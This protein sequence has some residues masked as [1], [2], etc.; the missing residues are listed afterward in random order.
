MLKYPLLRVVKEMDHQWEL[1]ANPDGTRTL[2]VREGTRAT[3][4]TEAMINDLERQRQAILL[5]SDPDSCQ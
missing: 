3:A 1:R 2:L 4:H 5:R